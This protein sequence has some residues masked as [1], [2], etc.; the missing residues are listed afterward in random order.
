MSGNAGKSG[1]GDTGLF[2]SPICFG[3][4]G[5]GN[6][7]DTYGYEVGEERALN[8]IRAIFDSSVNFIDVSRN[9]GFGR[10]EERIGKVIRQRKGLPE[11]FVISTKIDRDM[12]TNVLDG[13]RARRS[14]EESLTALGIEKFQLLHL[15]DPEYVADVNDVTG[16]GGALET[17]FAMKD[18]G[19]V[20]AVGLAAGNVDI[21]TPLLADW[22]FD[23]LV[24]HNR[25]T[26][27]NRN[28]E[29]M[30]NMA[31]DRGIA[32]L[33]AA[34]YSGGILAKGSSQFKRYVYMDADG[35]TLTPIQAIE[36]IVD[37]YGIPV[38]A[39]A[40]QFSMRDERV[41]ST[42][43]GVS[44]PERVQET[45]DWAQI[46]I[47]DDCWDELSSLQPSTN[48]PEAGRVYKPG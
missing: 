30:I 18:E 43:C 44:K 14:V 17:L 28:A 39:A 15:H 33:N 20:E 21:M 9:Y 36:R 22:D 24:T 45:L 7:P 8:T 46:D 27:V 40:L 35:A 37:K 13:D 47:P 5:L 31:V 25:F 16:P 38:G 48:D 26:L 19:L 23:A 10:S 4:S 32:V 3:T 42:V 29:R 1:I 12:A 11:E 41:T 34:P 2:V 6:M